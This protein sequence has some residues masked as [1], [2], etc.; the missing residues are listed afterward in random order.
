MDRLFRFT[1]GKPYCRQFFLPAAILLVPLHPY[2]IVIL[3]TLMTVSSV[4]N[5]LNLEIYPRGFAEHWLGQWLIGATHHSLHHS[6]FRCNYGLYFTFW[7]RW[8]GTESR[9]YLP[10]FRDRTQG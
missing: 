9:D 5:H 3:L 7:D 4:I 10:L 8:L 1:L 6:Q 2:A